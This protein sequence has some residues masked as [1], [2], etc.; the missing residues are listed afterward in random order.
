MNQTDFERALPVL[1]ESLQ[2]FFDLVDWSIEVSSSH[3]Q[4]SRFQ[5]IGRCRREA[6]TTRNGGGQHPKVDDTAKEEK[7][8]VDDDSSVLSDDCC[9]ISTDQTYGPG[10]HGKNQNIWIYSIVYSPTWQAPVLY[11]TAESYRDGTP[12]SRNQILQELHHHHHP[13]NATTTISEDGPWDFVSSE[14]HPMTGVPFFFLHP[15]QTLDCLATIAPFTVA[16][17]NNR[18]TVQQQLKTT[19]HRL[20]AWCAMVFPAAGLVIPPT[21]YLQVRHH[22]W[23][24]IC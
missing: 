15:C 11:F 12:L 8:L 19:L 22:L 18:E 14:E 20:W 2:R 13:N 4:D 24:Q 3:Y 23:E 9:C 10:E 7:L 21:I 1:Y 6:A 5:L 16:A 17:G